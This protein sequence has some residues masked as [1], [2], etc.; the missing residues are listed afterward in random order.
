MTAPLIPLLA[1]NLR[2]WLSAR[3]FVMVVVAS[4]VPLL[5]TGAWVV[6]HRADLAA[7]DLTWTPQEFREGDNVTFSATVRNAGGTNVDS[8]NA[9][10]AIGTVFNGRFLQ[11]AGETVE[12]EPLAPGATRQITL[13][14]TAQPGVYYAF[15]DVDPIGEDKIAEVDEF[16]NQLPVPFAVGYR[17]PGADEAPAA[18]ANLTGGPNATGV[19]DVS[20]E[21]VLPATFSADNATTIEA[22][23]R[24]DGPAA[25]EN[26]SVTLRIGRTFFGRFSPTQTLT[27]N[28]SLESGASRTFSLEWTAQEGAYWAEAF[29][30]AS[31]VADADAADNHAARAFTVDPVVGPDATPPKPPEKVTI[32]EFYLQVLSL[33]HLRILIPFIGLFYAAGVITDERERGT[34]AYILTRPVPRWTIP[35]AK[36]VASYVVAAIAITLGIVG[37]Y[38]VLFGTVP[39]GSDVGF[40][41][42][43][44][45]MSLLALFVYGAFFVLL[46]TLVERPYLVGVAFVIGWE[47]VAGS[48]VPWVRNITLSQHLLNAIALWPLDKG[49]QWVP[50]G[51]EG[52]RALR[53]ILIAA[54]AFLVA[55]A[56]V[57]K[58][59]EFEL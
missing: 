36:F 8:F 24:N 37:T 41:T 57:M 52:L 10:V 17:S 43:P 56:I 33:L 9:T 54:V 2:A 22:R 7:D 29:V 21:I 46:G 3:G 1:T 55:S 51:P 6:T 12:V 53:V 38:L 31:D 14:W 20:V 27:E 39:A 58:R 48:F 5:L 16:N 44:I 49:L 30:N 47:T 35:V 40:L 15:V 28:V 25:V 26:A 32:K 59:R 42:T 13:Q 19:A 23:V 4:L 50:E 45:L 18:P 11:T 34:L